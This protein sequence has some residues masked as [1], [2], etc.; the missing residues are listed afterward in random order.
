MAASAS[1]GI[2][3][4][5]S[6]ARGQRRATSGPLP[7]AASASSDTATAA[8]RTARGAEGEVASNPP[9]TVVTRGQGSVE[10]VGAWMLDVLSELCKTW[11]TRWNEYI[12][13]ACWTKHTMP[14]PFLPS[15]MTPFDLLFGPRTSFNM[16]VPQMDDTEVTRG[17]ENFIGGC[18]HSLREVWQALERLREGREKARQLH[19]ATI[20]RPSA[21]TRAAKGDLVL[22]RESDS[23]IH[24]QEICLLY[25]SDAADE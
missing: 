24:L 17:L 25:T 2:S 21:G 18:R 22:A 13:L 12:A 20:Q 10:R 11:P 5:V 9:R 4:A 14:D 7:G 19:K 3:A 6:P 15:T 1:S 23:L 16:L 8:R